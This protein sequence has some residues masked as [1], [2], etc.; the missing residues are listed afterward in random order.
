MSPPTSPHS[1]PK[2]TLL[3]SALSKT[4]SRDSAAT[5]IPAAPPSP[6]PFN[7][8]FTLVEDAHTPTTHHPTVHYIFSTDDSDQL[9]NTLLQIHDA[10]TAPP[11]PATTS[12][13]PPQQHKNIT[14][15]YILVDLNASGTAVESAHSLTG[16][17]QVLS[18]EIG[19]APTLEGGGG[20]G[21]QM[22]RVTGTEGMRV[23]EG[24]GVGLE[25]LVEAFGKRLDEL[26][27]VVDGG[28]GEAKRERE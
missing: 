6:Q 14:E 17:W 7:P 8:F 18:A 11:L 13:A 15:R 3:P 23:G 22:L 1:T 16:D 2:P 24:E 26:R 28:V 21:G 12:P 27:R 9:T 10:E 5:Q 25:G 4:T 19:K 20:E